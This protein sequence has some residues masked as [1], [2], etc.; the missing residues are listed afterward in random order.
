MREGSCFG[1]WG[2]IYNKPRTASAYCLTDVDLFCLDK[3]SFDQTLYVSKE[4]LI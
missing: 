1:E 2:L 4:S 3:I